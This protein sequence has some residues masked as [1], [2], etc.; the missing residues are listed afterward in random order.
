M[1]ARAA[2]AMLALLSTVQAAADSTVP[3]ATLANLAARLDVGEY[4]AAASGAEQLVSAIEASVGRYDPTLVAPL[5]LLGD[6]RMGLDDP[7]SALAAY[8]RAKHIVR[9]DDGV[10]GSSQIELLYREAEAL[11]A[12]GDRRAANDRHEFAYSLEARLHGKDAP[13]LIPAAYRLIDWYMH[14][15]KFRPA[16]VLYQQIIEVVKQAYPPTDPRVIEAVRGYARTYRLRRFGGRKPGRGGFYA[17]PPGH[18]KD[19]PWY[20]RATFQRGKRALKEVLEL[21]QDAPGLSNVEVATAM[22]EYADWNL[23]YYKYGV[24]MRY[25]RHAWALL[26]SNPAQRSEVFEKPNPLYLQLPNDPAQSSE[27][28]GRPRPGIVQLA[29]NVSHRGDVIGRKTLRSEPHNIMEFRLRKA[30]KN[31][32]Y[33]PAFRGGN[34]VARPELKL[35]FKY[36][37][38]PGDNGLAR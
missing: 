24:A 18:P 11:I 13:E 19:P 30:A 25:Y 32:R 28:L 16:Q 34:P 2:G 26:E 3:S 9:I 6:A 4:A 23:L 33:R 20:N 15:Y 38:Y 7:D 10:Q 14:N 36:Q 37:Y 22:V 21:T 31:A 8:D 27:P 5:K 17:W 29:L 35:E 1:G 12:I